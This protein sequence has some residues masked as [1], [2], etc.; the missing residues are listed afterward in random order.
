M[1][2][3]ISTKTGYVSS[4][5]DIS[6][7]ERLEVSGDQTDEISSF[8]F[9]LHTVFFIMCVNGFIFAQ[10]CWSREYEPVYPSSLSAAKISVIVLYS[11]IGQYFRGCFAAKKKKKNKC[12][13]Y[14]LFLTDLDLD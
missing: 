7:S 8:R 13:I 12:L 11:L 2:P 6:L 5:Y 14:N 1:I 10:Y 9:T 4:M 3:F